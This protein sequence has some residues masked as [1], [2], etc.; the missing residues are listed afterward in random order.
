MKIHANAPQANGNPKIGSSF[1]LLKG[2]R[3]DGYEPYQKSHSNFTMET[4]DHHMV[5]L[6]RKWVS[7]KR[8]D[9]CMYISWSHFNNF[10]VPIVLMVSMFFK[11]RVAK[12]RCSSSFF[13]KIQSLCSFHLFTIASF[14]P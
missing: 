8:I 5:D 1:V 10:D 14:D 7:K 3:G 12:T 4:Y 2:N 9:T 11:V 6:L 13:L